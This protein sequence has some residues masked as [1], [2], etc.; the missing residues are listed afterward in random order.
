M[1]WIV[2]I[3]GLVLL[4]LLTQKKHAPMPRTRR[5]L[6]EGEGLGAH[7]AAAAQQAD[8]RGYARTRLS[9][10]VLTRLERSISYLNG[11]SGN[12]LLPAAR[13]LCENGRFLQEEAA[14]SIRE[15]RSLPRLPRS[16]S[17]EPRIRLFVREAVQHSAANFTPDILSS[18]LAAWQQHL[19]MTNDELNALPVL[20]RSALLM[21]I[22]DLAQQC[23]QDQRAQQAAS[24]AHLLHKHGKS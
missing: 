17:S 18:A 20:L 16:L 8:G 2:L 13:W 3:A 15:H 11:L 14:V 21:D 4:F 9:S 23:E 10:S 6:P 1:Q 12:D 19:P 5:T 7:L 22:C 24:Q